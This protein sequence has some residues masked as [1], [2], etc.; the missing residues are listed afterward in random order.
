MVPWMDSAIFFSCFLTSLPASRAK[1]KQN[2]CNGK[3]QN[4]YE[5]EGSYGLGLRVFQPIEMQL[6]FS[7]HC[8]CRKTKSDKKHKCDVARESKKIINLITA[9]QYC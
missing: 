8:F 3:C 9:N 6:S 2:L 1:A 7:T 5:N 4:H